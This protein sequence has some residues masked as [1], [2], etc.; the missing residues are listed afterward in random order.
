VGEKWQPSSRDD[1]GNTPN[2]LVSYATSKSQRRTRPPNI[3]KSQ[4]SEKNQLKRHDQ[5]GQ[6]GTQKFPG[7][8][9]LEKAGLKVHFKAILKELR[10]RKQI[11]MQI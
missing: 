2:D 6:S 10:N 5:K 9:K 11:E 3:E 4:K 1:T 8:Q 7:N